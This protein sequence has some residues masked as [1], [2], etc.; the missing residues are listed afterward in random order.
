VQSA[1]SKA[2]EAGL[3][4]TEQ[5]WMGVTAKLSLA[6][7]INRR[8]RSLAL[9]LTKSQLLDPKYGLIPKV[10]QVIDLIDSGVGVDEALAQT[11]IAFRGPRGLVQGQYHNYTYLR[12]FLSDTDIRVLDDAI[13]SGVRESKPFPRRVA[14]AGKLR[15]EIGNKTLD[16][17]TPTEGMTSAQVSSFDKLAL[18]MTEWSEKRAMNLP[19]DVDSLA[20]QGD[21]NS[22]LVRSGS[23]FL[24]A[25]IAQSNR[26][27]V[28]TGN[29]PL[30]IRAFDVAYFSAIAYGIFST[31]DLISG[32]TFFTDRIESDDPKEQLSA[33]F[34]LVTYT[35]VAGF[36]AER[37][38]GIPLDIL[39]RKNPSQGARFALGTPAQSTVVGTVIPGVDAIIKKTLGEELTPSQLKAF[40]KVKYFNAFDTTIAGIARELASEAGYQ[41]WVDVMYP[42]LEDK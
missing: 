4:A 11:K 32:S 38:G 29:A 14:T 3:A 28:Q 41:D 10:R 19:G 9:F 17:I 1:S 16:M 34:D 20:W 25:P 22:I 5:V 24:K 35:G 37:F 7:H 18:L 12:G 27:F 2:S 6:D 39:T 15:L 33:Y 13:Q 8:T 36:G 21:P 40:R 26:T 23:M 30:A 42:E 31:R